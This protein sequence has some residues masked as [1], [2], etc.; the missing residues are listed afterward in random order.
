[1]G[2]FGDTTHFLPK[3]ILHDQ[4]C[5]NFQHFMNKIDYLLFTVAGVHT[6]DETCGFENDFC[7]FT[8]NETKWMFQR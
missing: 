7:I 1:M 2:I 4:S 6:D 8:F 5:L 3:F